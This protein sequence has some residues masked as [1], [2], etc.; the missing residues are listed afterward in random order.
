MVM[1]RRSQ[2]GSRSCGFES[3]PDTTIFFLFSSFPKIEEIY[4]SADIFTEADY[5]YLLRSGHLFDVALIWRIVKRKH[6]NREQRY[7][8]FI[9][10]KIVSCGVVLRNKPATLPIV[11]IPRIYNQE[12]GIFFNVES[13]D[14][15]NWMLES[16]LFYKILLENHRV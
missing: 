15:D 9:H 10:F 13:D 8:T 6:R 4:Q 3:Y 12:P 16:E 2:L 14:I 1:R 7:S 5:E 11:K